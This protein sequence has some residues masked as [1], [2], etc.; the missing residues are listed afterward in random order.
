MAIAP[1]TASSSA[2]SAG[3]AHGIDTKSA[4]G[5]KGAQSQDGRDWAKVLNVES[6][7]LI[8]EI[9]WDED[10]DSSISEALEDA[11]GDALLDIDTD[12]VVDVV[13]LWWRDEDG[14]LVDGLVDATR[15]LG[16]DGSIWLLTPAKADAG[17]V[18]PG[19]IAESA[20]LAG[21]VQTKSERLGNWQGACLV[22]SGTKR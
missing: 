1:G 7:Y 12:E 11:I 4:Q 9:G 19:V 22:S 16:E 20:Q 6:D 5:T 8:Q 10:C 13:L 2:G 14:D 21:L 17:R 15:S 18:E 3:G